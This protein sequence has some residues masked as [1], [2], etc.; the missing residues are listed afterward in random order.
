MFFLSI[1]FSKIS[2]IGG[3]SSLSGHC[4]VISVTT[5]HADFLPL[6]NSE[7]GD[8]F[9]G[10]KSESL[11]A[12]SKSFTADF[13]RGITTFTLN[14]FGVSKNISFFPYGILY[15]IVFH[16]TI[17]IKTNSVLIFATLKFCG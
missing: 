14:S 13:L 16:K 3:K 1:S 12:V 7:S 11:M 5:I 4:L 2:R 17:K 6:I 15:P 9:I 8:E 10:C